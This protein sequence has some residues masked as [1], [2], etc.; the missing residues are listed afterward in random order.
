MFCLGAC[1]CHPYIGSLHF[2][3]LLFLLAEDD[4]EKVIVA[5]T[6]PDGSEIGDTQ[7]VDVVALRDSFEE[8]T[9]S[10]FLAI[11]EIDDNPPFQINTT[12]M[13]IPLL[14]FDSE[15]SFLFVFVF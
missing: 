15:K 12:R 11:F 10:L 14:I 8:D 6:F 9:E 7:C 3:L 13:V 4:I 1:Q 2:L 5:V